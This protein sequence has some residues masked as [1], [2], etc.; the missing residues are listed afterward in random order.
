MQ[1]CDA[2]CGHCWREFVV[3]WKRRIKSQT[4]EA[5]RSGLGSFNLAASTSVRAGED[6]APPPPFSVTPMFS[7]GPF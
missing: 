1:S 3:W 7:L 5:G 2:T 4:R 6:L